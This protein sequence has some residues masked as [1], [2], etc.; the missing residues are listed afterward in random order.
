MALYK[1]VFPLGKGVSLS[2]Y[3]KALEEQNFSPYTLLVEK[4][5]GTENYRIEIVLTD[6]VPGLWRVAGQ[7]IDGILFS[8]CTIRYSKGAR[9]FTLE[10]SV[11]K[12][13]FFFASFYVTLALCLF[14]FTLFII[15]R[16]RSVEIIASSLIIIIAFLAPLTTTYI[17]DRN[18]LERIGSIALELNQ[19]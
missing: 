11:R 6:L 14:L 17:R 19:K 13:N 15:T 8:E 12:V 7:F 16:G 2:R 5:P 3:I 9:E 4:T 10:A 18:R 1:K